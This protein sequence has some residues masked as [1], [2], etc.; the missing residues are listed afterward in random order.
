MVWIT[1]VKNLRGKMLTEIVKYSVPTVLKDV[2]KILS[3]FKNWYE[4][5]EQENNL[6]QCLEKK[7]TKLSNNEMV[8]NL[9]GTYNNVLFNKQ[10]ILKTEWISNIS[11]NSK[12]WVIDVEEMHGRMN[13]SCH[14]GVARVAQGPSGLVRGFFVGGAVLLMEAHLKC[15]TPPVPNDLLGCKASRNR[16]DSCPDL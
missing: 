12:E 6:W 16:P 13:S 2:V 1:L 10:C 15:K 14:Q 8:I 4:N 7:W 3:I 11:W 9:V 5:K